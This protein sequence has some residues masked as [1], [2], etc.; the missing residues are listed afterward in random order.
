MIEVLIERALNFMLFWGIWLLVP[1]IADFSVAISY[2]GTLLTYE[3]EKKEIKSLSYYPYVTVVVP[4]LNSAGTLGKCLLSVINQTYPKECLQIICVDNGSRDNSFEVFQQIQYKYQDM[5]LMWATV[6]RASKSNALNV[7]MYSSQGTYLINLD[8]DT[9]LDKHAIWN[10][11]QEFESDPT[12]MA[13]TAVI[14]VDKELVK[15]P[16]LIDIVNYCEIV[17]YLVAFNVGRRYQT[18]TNTLFTLSGAFSA[19]RRETIL[20]TFLY[21]ERTVSEDTDLTFHI[22]KFLKATS[23][24]IGCV[25]EAIAYVEPIESLA[26]LYSQRVRWQ[27]GEIEVVAMYYENIPG[28]FKALRDFVGRT[29]ILDHTLAFSRLAWTFLIPF[30]YFI[31][32]SLAMVMVAMGGLFVCYLFIEGVYFY[33]GYRGATD[34][35]RDK[36]KKIWWV[37]FILPFYRYM[38]YWFRVGGIVQVV[39]ET[40]SWRV[41]NPIEETIQVLKGYEKLFRILLYKLLNRFGARGG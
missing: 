13:A 26:R 16:G 21:Q 23:M 37:V 34:F 38:S 19:F 22:R 28:A 31:G 5:S 30:L 18:I 15:R 24:R 40:K 9:W 39:A 29:I 6:D 1:L 36:L 20:K 10:I 4:V 35:Y 33:V 2:L 32:Y 7:G 8:S 27:R 17:E 11:V 12:L 14:C 3:K 25:E 41:E